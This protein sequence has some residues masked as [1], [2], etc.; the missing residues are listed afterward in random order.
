MSLLR[1]ELVPAR[2]G[3]AWVVKRGE[4]IRF[5][6]VEGGQI[7][8]LVVF[9]ADNIR[10]RFNQSRTRSNQGKFLISTG[11]HLY[12]KFNNIMLTIVEDTYGT[13]DLQYGMCS[14]FVYQ[15]TKHSL[16][17][18]FPVG[19]PL[20]RPEVGCWEILTETMKP[21]DVPA[22]DVPDPLNLFQTLDFDFE[23]G[24]FALAEGRSKPGDHVDMV[25]GMDVIAALSAC[26]VTG[27]PLRVEIY[28]T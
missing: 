2:E 11:D 5:V 22:E 24:R 20:G 16:A 12:S 3:R 8:D 18:G 10:E 9:N 14:R 17:E 21:W 26:P 6:D 1:E 27:R 7:G 13:H 28:E 25:A 15:R 4:R 23:N 19:G